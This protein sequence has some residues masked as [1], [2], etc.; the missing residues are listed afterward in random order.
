MELVQLVDTGYRVG[1]TENLRMTWMNASN[2]DYT[3]ATNTTVEKSTPAPEAPPLPSNTSSSMGAAGEDFFRMIVEN[4]EDLFAV[5]DLD[6]HRLYNSPSYERLFGAP[7]LKRGSDSFAE[8]HPEDREKVVSAFQDTVRTGR[9][10]RL[11]F[12]FMLADGT[13]RCMESCGALIR[14]S[15][16]EPLRVAVVSRDITEH[17]EQERQIH[18]LAF[19]DSLTQ[20]PNRRLL[21]DRLELAM[22]T[23]RRSGRHA[24]LMI[25]DLDN[26]KQLND[27][28]GHAVGDE[29]L[30]E[31]GRR[32]TACLRET[33][34]VAR[35]G[36]DE[37]VLL[38]GELSPDRRESMRQA[39]VVAEKIREVLAEPY[40]LTLGSGASN[41][42]TIRHQCTASTGIALFLG[43]ETDMDV[44]LQQADRAMYRAKADG[45]NGI[46]FYESGD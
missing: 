19:Y 41:R 14:D 10:H 37:F 31:V 32:I 34:M 26:F 17:E 16:G 39:T 28:Q 27:Q 6:G 12:R 18:H 43:Q 2:P 38:F 1:P 4:G 21:R 11:N 46:R 9:S 33:D 20:L 25:L 44:V 30:V 40:L 36:G 22:A 8:I 5:L 35:Y 42:K 29:L 13:V 15:S 3:A 45:R 24:A 23:S 7:G